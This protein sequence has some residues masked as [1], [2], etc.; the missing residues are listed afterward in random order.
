MEMPKVRKRSTL[1]ELAEMAGPDDIQLVRETLGIEEPDEELIIKALNLARLLENKKQ[2]KIELGTTLT[3]GNEG[4]LRMGQ[5]WNKDYLLYFYKDGRWRSVK[6]ESPVAP[7]GGQ[8]FSLRS[9]GNQDNEE[10]GGYRAAST[11]DLPELYNSGWFAV[12]NDTT[13]T[14]GTSTGFGSFSRDDMNTIKG[15]HVFFSTAASSTTIYT[16]P[17]NSTAEGVGLKINSTRI[18]LRTGSDYVA[19]YWNGSSWT[20]ATSGYLKVVVS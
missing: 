1:K 6:A 14:S 9:S 4:D 11:L 20:S 5:G 13:Y 19:K 18:S 16:I 8:G 2:N 15:I 10:R 3:P 17:E 7:G 12:N